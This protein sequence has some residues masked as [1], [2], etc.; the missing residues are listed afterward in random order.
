VL[1]RSRTAL[2]LL[3]ESS[4]VE[5]VDPHLRNL[6]SVRSLKGLP[7]A[8]AE[9]ALSS[10]D[11]IRF[12]VTRRPYERLA[13]AWL[14][15]IFVGQSDKMTRPYAISLERG[16]DVGGLFREFISTSD[17]EPLSRREV[18][19]APQ[20]KLLQ[21]DTTPYNHVLDI[22]E[23][24]SFAAWVRSSHES[25]Q[26]FDLSA[27][28]NQSLKVPLRAMYDR[29]TATIVEELYREDFQAFGYKREDFGEHADDFLL[30]ENELMLTDLVS[31]LEAVAFM[32]RE[33]LKLADQRT[34]GRYAVQELIRVVRRRSRKIN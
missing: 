23:L 3:E 33:K 6:H 8:E 15:K 12:C 16:R 19:F 21:P 13:S 4:R 30:T 26:K 31:S 22:S 14:N 34:G 1:F 25:R 11:W 10:P 20:V 24:D 9:V 32:N 27:R 5:V 29:A 28:R 17:L 18:H 7:S 2:I